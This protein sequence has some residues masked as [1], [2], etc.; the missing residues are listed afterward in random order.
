M[1]QRPQNGF[2]L[3]IVITVLT[4][5]ALEMFVLAVSSNKMLFQSNRAYLQTVERNLRASGLVWAKKH[6][7][8]TGEKGLGKTVELDVGKM[9]VRNAGLKVSVGQRTN[10]VVEVQISTSC[11]RGRQNLSNKAIYRLSP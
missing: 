6:I 8:D 7:K 3:V 10:N 4:V 5:V 2:I 11:S 1:K 9:D